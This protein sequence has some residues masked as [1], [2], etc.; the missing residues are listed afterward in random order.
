[1]AVKPTTPLD[2]FHVGFSGI[3]IRIMFVTIAVD[4]VKASVILVGIERTRDEC[5]SHRQIVDTP[6]VRTFEINEEFGVCLCGWFRE[7]GLTSAD[8][9]TCVR[10]VGREMLALLYG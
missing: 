10:N 8:A 5:G 3:V 6:Y 9:T 7:C 1:M 4:P 2:L